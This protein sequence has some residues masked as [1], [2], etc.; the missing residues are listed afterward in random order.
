MRK[1]A[2]SK[3]FVIQILENLFFAVERHGASHLKR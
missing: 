3:H 1:E 2:G